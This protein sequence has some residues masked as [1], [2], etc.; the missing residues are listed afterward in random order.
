MFPAG[1]LDQIR[2][3]FTTQFSIE[4]SKMKYFNIFP[5]EGEEARHYNVDS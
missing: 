4:Y 5:S 1:S 2:F 3:I